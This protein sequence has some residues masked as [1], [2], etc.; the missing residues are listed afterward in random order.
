MGNQEF[1]DNGESYLVH[2][3]FGNTPY[4]FGAIFL[5]KKKL[6]VVSTI[7]TVAQ[8]EVPSLSV[9]VCTYNRSELLDGCLASL[10]SQEVDSHLYEIIVVDNNSKDDTLALVSKYIR[11][12]ENIRYVIESQQGLSHARNTGSN[13]ARGSYLA[14]I[15]DDAI[16]PKDY[17]LHVLKLLKQHTPDI[18]GGPIYPYYTTKKPWWFRDEYEIREFAAESGFTSKCRV[19]GGNFIIRKDILKQ[20]GMFNPDL[21]MIGNKIGLGEERALLEKYRKETTREKLRVYYS[22]ESYVKHHVPKY[23]MRIRY[24]LSRSFQSGRIMTRIKEK[25]PKTAIKRI[26]QYIPNQFSYAYDEIRT[27][28]LMRADYPAILFNMAIRL[29]N[30]VELFSH[31][32]GPVFK[33]WLTV[34]YKRFRRLCK[35]WR[36]TKRFLFWFE[37]KTGIYEKVK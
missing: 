23:K 3:R 10:V 29:G 32:L 16:V 8:P 1:F 18:M 5:R 17:L 27:K 12:H 4:T 7:S 19:S 11:N 14:Y 30:I 25:E 34:K 24:M 35:K 9:I 21:G 2:H 33:P 20:L 36:V 22:L 6:S 28:G 31:G 13:E 37:N 15:D 26:I